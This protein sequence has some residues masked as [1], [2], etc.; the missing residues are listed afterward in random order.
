MCVSDFM[1]LQNRVGRSGIVFF[2]QYFFYC[3]SSEILDKFG[4]K[5]LR[6]SLKV[7]RFTSF[8]LY[9]ILNT[10]KK[11][12]SSTTKQP[13]SVGEKRVKYFFIVPK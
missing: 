6:T 4:L 10:K 11:T 2:L 5:N 7:V 9:M 1:G 12:L 8:F 13:E 3:P